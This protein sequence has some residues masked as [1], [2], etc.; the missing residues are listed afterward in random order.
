MVEKK[1]VLLET[2]PVTLAACQDYLTGEGFQVFIVPEEHTAIQTS[3]EPPIDLILF[4]YSQDNPAGMDEIRKARRMNPGVTILSL[5]DLVSLP[6]AIRCLREDVD[7]ILLRPV[8]DRDELAAAV[9]D[10]MAHSRM[11]YR[12]IGL[13][14]IRPVFDY[15]NSANFDAVPHELGQHILAEFERIFN[16]TCAGIY[17]S[18]IAEVDWN[19]LYGD[20][21]DVLTGITPQDLTIALNSVQRYGKELVIDPDIE[22]EAYNHWMNKNDLLGF[23][24]PATWRRRQYVFFNL[25]PAKLSAPDYYQ[26]QEINLLVTHSVIALDYMQMKSDLQIQSLR[27]EESQKSL[28]AAEKMA[29]LGR[30]IGTVAH[31]VNNPLQSLTNCLHLARRPDVSEEK[32]QYYLDLALKR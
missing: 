12:P 17:C 13:E 29:A 24:I 21:L 27:L 9:Q 20:R 25:R 10:A 19:I 14:N 22:N 32:K 8:M 7:G 26:F 6:M 18:S 23:F 28:L 3:Q 15:L 2:D 30:L 4:P 16:S 31:E 11:R 5:S 1:A